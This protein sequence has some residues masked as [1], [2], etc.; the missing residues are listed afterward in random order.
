MRKEN[1]RR[2]RG[3]SRKDNVEKNRKDKRKQK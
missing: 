1:K 3:K 2:K